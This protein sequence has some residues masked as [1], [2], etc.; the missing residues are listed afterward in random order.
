M[1]LSGE[2]T[3][4]LKYAFAETKNLAKHFLTVVTAV[5]VFS[6]TFSEKLASFHTASPVVR[7]SIVAAW[8]CMF[9][10]IVSGGIAICYV[11]LSG[12]QSMM[13]TSH[14]TAAKPRQCEHLIPLT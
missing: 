14:T 13:R 11:A 8:T 4:F 12:G 6:L 3:D 1:P 9:L 7:W 5:L 10:A 2:A